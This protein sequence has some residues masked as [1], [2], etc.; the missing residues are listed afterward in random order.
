MAFR[1]L[2][3]VASVA[4]AVLALTACTTNQQQG[5]TQDIVFA[6]PWSASE[7]ATYRI[8]RDG[9]I[10]GRGVFRIEVE[11][12]AL[13]LTQEFAFPEREFEDVVRARVDKQTLKP[14]T[15]ERV[16]TGPEGD[17]NW[18]VNYVSGIAEVTQ[19]GGGDERTDQI[20]IP[21]Y[22]YESW[23]D[24]FLWRTI[25][26]STGYRASYNDML[27]A[28]LTRPRKVLMS[29]QVVGLESVAVAAGQFEAWKLEI[30]AG[31]S[32]QVAWYSSD[33]ER[34]LL[35]YDNG[36]LEFELERAS[37]GG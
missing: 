18:E 20:N 9:E 27:T 1:V 2:W 11:E 8:L 19:T 29:L 33:E 7:E 36:E 12:D 26:F 32:R 31:G 17:R 34:L 13:L 10:I 5:P 3:A 15:V 28:V 23:S 30:R 25:D 21:E 4:L 14:L 16:I 24:L 35:R 37:S 22:H 6:I